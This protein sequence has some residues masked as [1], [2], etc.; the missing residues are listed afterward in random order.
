[1]EL[2]PYIEGIKPVQLLFEIAGLLGLGSL[3][4]YY[5]EKRGRPLNKFLQAVSFLAIVFIYFEYRLYP[6]L[7]LTVRITYL[8]VSILGILI[9]ASSNEDYWKNFKTP[10]TAVLDAD[11]EAT[12]RIRTA[13][14]IL[15]PLLA[16]LVTY[17]MVSL[18]DPDKNVPVDQRTHFP[19]PPATIVVNSPEDFRR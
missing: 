16:W 18:P 1:M 11:T 19:A 7:P 13:V 10:L 14:L 6:P 9:W 17:L 8:V 3:V 15:L 4:A 2:L 5:F 12:R